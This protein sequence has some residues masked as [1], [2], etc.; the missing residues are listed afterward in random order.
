MLEGKYTYQENSRIAVACAI[1]RKTKG[2]GGYG[3]KKTSQK[4][5]KKERERDRETERGRETWLCA[6]IPATMNCSQIA[7]YTL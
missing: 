7:E 2:Q 6:Q 5:R 4:E 1:T 3:G